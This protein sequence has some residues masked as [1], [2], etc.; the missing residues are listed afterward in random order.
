MSNYFISG[1]I[2]TGIAN[3]IRSKTGRTGLIKP[4]AMAEAITNI[5]T[6]SA[7][8]INKGLIDGTVGE[9]V[10]PDDLTT[11][12]TYAFYY[13]S[14]LVLQSIPDGVI[15][16]GGSS[17]TNCTS[18]ALTKLPEN[19]QQIQANAFMNCTSLK[20]SELP[21]SVRIIYAGAFQGC[22]GLTEITF[23]STPTVLSSTAFTGCT[24]LTTINVPWAENEITQAP[25]GAPNAKVNYNYTE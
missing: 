15:V 25:W 12:R 23:R 14:S 11:I 5:Q 6:T 1:E 10:L 9:I 8:A 21:S 4:S 3:A 19:V 24:N 2:F 16:I 7:S 22:T 18:L 17:F 13:C 20:I